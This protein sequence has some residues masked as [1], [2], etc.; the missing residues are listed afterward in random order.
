MVLL[1]SELL[2]EEGENMSASAQSGDVDWRR[3]FDKSMN[4]FAWSR[5]I[6]KPCFCPCATSPPKLHLLEDV[7][8]IS[9]GSTIL[10]SCD[11]DNVCP[12][13]KKGKEHFGEVAV[14]TVGG[15]VKCMAVVVIEATWIFCEV[16]YRPYH[17]LKVVK[18]EVEVPKVGQVF[19]AR[20]TMSSATRTGK[21]EKINHWPD[22][23]SEWLAVAASLKR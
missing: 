5:D 14:A 17:L 3:A 22:N 20:D 21:Q 15:I 10:V 7:R 18:C 9:N 1:V 16:K 19:V 13:W 6:S 2:N 23:S 12:S 11:D 8:S 4:F